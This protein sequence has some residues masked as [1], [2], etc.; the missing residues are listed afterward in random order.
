MIGWKYMIHIDDSGITNGYGANGELIAYGD[1]VEDCLK[2]AGMLYFNE[3]GSPPAV[4]PEEQNLNELND[5]DMRRAIEFILNE[6][7]FI[8][9][10]G[11][12]DA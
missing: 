7:A 2:N 10:E 4:G 12:E 9:A 8:D 5:Q 11:G 6:I 1:S 3:V